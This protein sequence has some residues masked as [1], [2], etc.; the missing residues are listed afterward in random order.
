MVVQDSSRQQPL[1][2]SASSDITGH[3]DSSSPP[4]SPNGRSPRV[5]EPFGRSA[6]VWPCGEATMTVAHSGDPLPSNGPTQSEAAT[7][8]CLAWPKGRP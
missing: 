6:G 7:P 4:E 3:V 5:Q 8:A 2:L 1:V